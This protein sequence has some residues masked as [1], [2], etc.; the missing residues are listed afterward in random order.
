MDLDVA[1]CKSIPGCTEYTWHNGIKESIITES[2]I[3]PNS[4]NRVFRD[5]KKDYS[6]I[7][8]RNNFPDIASYNSSVFILQNKHQQPV[9]ICINEVF[10][11]KVS[12]RK[13]TTYH[14][15]TNNTYV[16]ST[17]IPTDKV[18]YI[19]TD[20]TAV[21]DLSVDGKV[22]VESFSSSIY[23]KD[24]FYL[25]SEYGIPIKLMSK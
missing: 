3:N 8:R 20:L 15:K 1:A 11:D 7:I 21:F 4:F 12:K 9:P 13:I 25:R 24:L 16:I 2:S 5:P 19:A 17:S 6:I 22:D 10:H 23:K 14:D 18:R